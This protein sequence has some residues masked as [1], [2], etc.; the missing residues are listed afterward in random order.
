MSL[1]A[2]LLSRVKHTKSKG[3]I[4]PNLKN[5]VRASARESSHKRRLIIISGFFTISIISGILIIYSI[6]N[7][8]GVSDKKVDMTKST[9]P[10]ILAR[11]NKQIQI[12]ENRLKGLDSAEKEKS[13]GVDI[14]PEGRE[15]SDNRLS[16]YPK[17]ALQKNSVE[18][19][20]I[21][22]KEMLKTETGIDS[23]R[24]NQPLK[25]YDEKTAVTE[26]KET[27]K[28][29]R[30]DAFERDAYLYAA[31]DY[32]LKKDYSKALS[33]Y[34]KVLEMDRDNVTVMNNIA[35]ILLHLGLVEESIKYSQKAVDINKDYVPALINL[36][37]AHTK[38]GDITAAGEYLKSAS[39][40]EPDNQSIIFNLAIFYEK[41]KD[42]DT[43]SEYYT[44]LI[45]LGSV[46]GFLGLARV[47]EKKGSIEEALKIYKRIYSLDSIDDK[48]RILV[49]QRV[50]ILNEKLRMRTEK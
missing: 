23:Y 13:M 17:S 5:I 41:Q 37:V 22:I 8:T 27:S 50:N 29:D 34:K 11:A 45:H 31:R 32:E 2:D 28:I 16:G 43:A 19:P 9:P 42:Y 49:D 44:K 48:T 12:D 6:Q 10:E 40:L 4:P 38:L 39:I 15:I 25:E 18:K 26:K 46:E 24:K 21:K 33:L 47:Y 35:Y 3:D 36:G 1:L 20:D 30:I 14:S 7:L